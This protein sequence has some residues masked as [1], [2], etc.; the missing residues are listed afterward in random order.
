[1]KHRS[2]FNTLGAVVALM[3][4]FTLAIRGNE[5]PAAGSPVEQAIQPVQ[6]STDPAAPGKAAPQE[7]ASTP[8][9]AVA[10]AS[11]STAPAAAA[12]AGSDRTPPAAKAAAPTVETETPRAGL[13]RI[14]RPSEES[15]ADNH[16][17]LRDAIR[18]SVGKHLRT[19]KAERW[20]SERVSVMHDVMVDK[21]EKTTQ[22]VAVFGDTTVD[23]EA[24]DQA[25]SVWGSTTVNGIVGGQAVSVLGNTTINGSVGDQAVAVGGNMIVNG[26]VGGQVVCVGG[27]LTLG[28]DADVGGEIVLV[29][30][31]MNRDPGA[32]M[33]G[34]V[35]QVHL[36]VLRPIVAWATSALLN[37]RL[38]SFAPRAAWA[39]FV[40][41]AFLG[42]YVLLALV[43]PQGMTKCVETL[44][45]RPGHV[46]LTA[47]LT[48]LAM[49]LVFVLLAITGV[50][51]L[52]IPFLGVGLFAAKLFGR[53]TMLAWLGR[54]FGGL[55]G[56]GI[57]SGLV[58]S[59][60]C[61]GIIVALLYTIPILAFIVAMLISV[62]GLGTVIYTLILT[63][64]KNGAKPAPATP[65]ALP[66]GAPT[67]PA[68][69]PAVALA[70]E[71][72]A[73]VVAGAVP[74]VASPAVPPAVPSAAAVAIPPAI[75]VAMPAA[76][77]PGAPCATPPTVISAA[78]LPRAGF[79][80]RTAALFID[81]ILCAIILKLIPFTHFNFGGFLLILAIYGAVMWKLRGTTVGGS[82]CHLKV[83]RLDERTMDWTCTI[84]RALRC[85]YSLAVVGLGFLWVAFDDEKQSWHDKIAGTTVVIVPKGVSL[86]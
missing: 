14:D 11:T 59:V 43:F 84:V 17:H 56:E 20:K 4:T 5:A 65:V 80:I 46:I 62:L 61:G 79:W 7:S 25:V 69:A 28:P 13:R 37:G 58:M 15:A 64:R 75:P 86:I 2:L 29:G 24:D 47:L 21:D 39:W 73:A 72:Q 60:L 26:H 85:L 45:Q 35:Q 49:P 83:V 19:H 41:A 74:P 30:G 36:P 6:A 50:G 53:A 34:E 78:T 27:D 31:E 3:L 18:G 22:A 57:W 42:F 23:G 82:I 66:A 40:A 71:V 38:L 16:N 54:R 48:M 55:L 33:H 8:A 70:A 77:V 12:L 1:M 10:P 9:P 67:Q 81:G 32:V 52:V 76:T 68:P 63:T 44:E 51:V